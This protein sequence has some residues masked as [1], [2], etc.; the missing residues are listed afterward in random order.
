[1]C[2][3]HEDCPECKEEKERLEREV[4]KYRRLL[5]SAGELMGEHARI[6]YRRR[7]YEGY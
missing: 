7:L 4:E 5:H 1:M 2:E 3:E 6:S